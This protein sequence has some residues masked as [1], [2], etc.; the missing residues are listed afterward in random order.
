LRVSV[1]LVAR[2]RAT[3]EEQARFVKESCGWVSMLNVPDLLRYPIRSW[4][5]CALTAAF[6]PQ[7]V[8]HLRSIDMSPSAPLPMREALARAGLSEVLVVTGDPPDDLRHVAYPVTSTAL[9]RRLKR[10]LPHLKV[11]AAVDPYRQS[12]RAEKEYVSRKL[13]AGADGFFTQP[14][15]DMWLV[16]LYAELLMPNAVFWG[17]SPVMTPGARAYWETRNDVPFPRGFAATLDWN[18]A[19]A[20]ELLAFARD[21]DSNAYVMPLRIELSRYLPL[22]T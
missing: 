4:D 5:A 14:F 16:E 17:V 7:S 13:D 22:L 9:I 20:R 1:E 6:F 15:F 2:D 18:I 10:E 8:P 11:Y 12:F 19:F 3:L 21:T